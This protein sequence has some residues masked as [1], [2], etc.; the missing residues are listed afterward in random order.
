MVCNVEVKVDSQ[1]N[2]TNDVG[3]S[4]NFAE[5]L[6]SEMYAAQYLEYL[7]KRIFY[8]ALATNNTATNT[9]ATSRVTPA[10]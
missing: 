7:T 5:C 8:A 4:D 1:F 2:S 3:G 6:L 10:I 9:I